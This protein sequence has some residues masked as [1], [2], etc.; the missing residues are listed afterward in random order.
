[1]KEYHRSCTD[2]L[3]EALKELGLAAPQV[4]SPFNLWMNIPW[5]EKPQPC[6][7]LEFVAPVSKAGDYIVMRAEMD[8]IVAFSACPQ[9][10][11]ATP[12][13]H[14][15]LCTLHIHSSASSYSILHAF[16]GSCSNQEG[17][18]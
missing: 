12:V 17:G 7:S 4:P 9:V 15:T 8:C 6:G 11:L 16:A 2:N 13:S 18:Q 5:T 1:M 3:H 10:T 14:V